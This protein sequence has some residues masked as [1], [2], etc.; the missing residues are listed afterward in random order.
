MSIQIWVRLGN[1]LEHH[2]DPHVLVAQQRIAGAQQEH[3]GEQVPLDLEERVRTRVERLADDRVGRADQ[4]RDQNDPVNEMADLLVQ[5]V[6]CARQP[7]QG[8]HVSPLLV[9]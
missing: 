4:D 3:R 7:Q 5:P 8:L 1:R 9:G 2:V 6:D